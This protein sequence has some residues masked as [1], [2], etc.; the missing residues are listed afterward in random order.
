MTSWP[1][2]RSRKGGREERFEGSRRWFR[3]RIV[4]ALRALPAGG[5]L[6]LPELGEQVK[7]GFC[8]EELPWL[9]ELVEA[10]ARDGLVEMTRGTGETTRVA[11]PA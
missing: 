5:S 6:D 8:A 9:Q 4:A 2:L 3:G 7:P 1:A 11:L 10:L